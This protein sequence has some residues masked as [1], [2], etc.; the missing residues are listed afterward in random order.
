[1]PNPLPP[2]ATIDPAD[3]MT[4]RKRNPLPPGATVDGETGWQKAADFGEQ[5]LGYGG[6]AAIGAVGG[7]IPGAIA[8][9]AIGGTAADMDIARRHNRPMGGPGDVAKDLGMNVVG[10]AAGE[11]IGAVAGKALGGLG[12]VARGE[13]E[14]RTAAQETAEKAAGLQEGAASKQA[15]KNLAERADAYQKAQVAQQDFASKRLDIERNT[16][17]QVAK[18]REKIGE[19]ASKHGVPELHQGI[20][21]SSL[22]RTPE[23]T[24]AAM[25]HPPRRAPHCL[26]RSVWR[27]SNASTK[28][29]PAR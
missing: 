14:Y 27:N 17:D 10:A 18:A 25:T 8:G 22:G 3:P 13:S 6:G 1:M 7:S 16:A 29:S 20:I 4:T 2:G 11:G 21:A 26:A 28:T 24:T 15:E 5:A 23:Q 12:K 19:K 9:G